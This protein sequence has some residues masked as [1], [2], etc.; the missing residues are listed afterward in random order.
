MGRILS[1]SYGIAAYAAFLV[2]ILYAIGFVGDWLVP[3]SID[4][5]VPAPL[6]TA[7]VVNLALLGLFAAQH[8][9]MARPAFKRWWTRF[10]PTALERS[11]YVLLASLALMLLFWQWQPLPQTVWNVEGPAARAL[12]LGVCGLGW[13]TAFVSTFLIHHFELLG[14]RQVF[15]ARA[16]RQLPAPRFKTPSLYR[17]VRHPLYLGFLLAFWATPHMSAGHLLFAL[18]ISGYVLLGI[19]LEERDLIELFGNQYRRYRQRVNMLLPGPERR[20]A[21]PHASPDE[22]EPAPQSVG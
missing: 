18:A 3:K 21:R 14:V 6:A 17:Y 8:S 12:L 13:V 16:N 2:T 4:T 7:I 10:V 19:Q 22:S 5:G 20:A 1:V 11:T 9:V 15:A